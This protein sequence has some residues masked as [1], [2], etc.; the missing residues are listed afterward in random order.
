MAKVLAIDLDE[1]E[2]QYPART[3]TAAAVAQNTTTFSGKGKSK[4]V[5][6][7]GTNTGHMSINYGAGEDTGK[8][9]LL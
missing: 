4:D 5:L 9:T 8:R 7:V 6:Q 2:L 3:T 1:A